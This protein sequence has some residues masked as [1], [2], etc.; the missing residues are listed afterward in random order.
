MIVYVTIILLFC[1]LEFI[2]ETYP[3]LHSIIYTIFIFLFLTYLAQSAIFPFI[4]QALDVV[5]TVILPVIKLLLFSVFLLFLSQIVE[6]LLIDYEYTSLAT[7]ITFTTK[8]ILL[9]VWFQHMQ[10]FFEKFISIFGLLT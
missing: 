7:I 8:A 9:I 1:L 2:K 6:E 10:P 3:R 4:N 5:P